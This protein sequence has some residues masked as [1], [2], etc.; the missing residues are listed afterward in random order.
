MFEETI[1]HEAC[2][3]VRFIASH[4]GSYLV[5]GW[6]KRY[7]DERS[8]FDVWTMDIDIDKP[9]DNKEV[10]PIPVDSAYAVVA[11]LTNEKV[12]KEDDPK[13]FIS[14]NNYEV[15]GISIFPNPAGE[16]LNVD[17]GEDYR[18]T[19]IQI[20]NQSGTIVR[21]HSNENSSR[22]QLNVADLKSGWYV[23]R[24]VCDRGITNMRFIK[25]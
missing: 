22:F 15:H 16:V 19:E 13:F 3:G 12:D 8:I 25:F 1:D 4:N 10:I 20:F 18:F 23:I 6:T 9:E 14:Y 7:D 5:A 11:E 17:L 2:Q 21:Q 24:F